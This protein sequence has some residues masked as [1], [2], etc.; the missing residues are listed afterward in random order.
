[1]VRRSSIVLALL[2]VLLVAAVPA[3]GAR[4]QARPHDGGTITTRLTFVPDCLDPDKTTI[5]TAIFSDVLDTLISKDDQGRLSPDLATRWT[6]GN[7]GKVI[8]FFLRHGVKFSN[9]DAFTAQDVKFTLARGLKSP[10]AS[11]QFG[12]LKRVKVTNPYTVRL[13]MSTPYRPLFTN[14][15]G[16]YGGIMDPAAVRRLGNKTCTDPVGTGPFMIKS[17]G[18]GFN[19]VV[20]VRNPLHTWNPP[21]IKN[22]FGVAHIARLVF[23][24]IVSDSTATSELLTGGVDISQVVADQLPRV[25]SNANIRLRPLALPHEEYLGFNTARA[26]FNSVA[27]RRALAE[28]V[29]RKAIMKVAVGSFGTPAYSALPDL[30]PFYDKRSPSYAVQYNPTAARSVL[31]ANHV[32][33]PYTL[34]TYDIP[35]SRTAAE[36]MQA[37]LAQVGVTTNVVIKSFA[38]GGSLLSKGN[39]DLYLGQYGYFDA[40]ILYLFFH[41]SQEGKGNN[42]TF[43]KNPT[44]DALLTAGNSTYN[45]QTAGAIYAKV[46]KLLD[47]EVV[48]DP[49][50]NDRYYWGVRTKVKGFWHPGEYEIPYQDLWV[51]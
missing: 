37:E 24:P 48:T 15:A 49:L 41:S 29:D 33:G 6:I 26:P 7:G 27:V 47:T 16:G 2:S 46:Q 8:T 13:I 1:M 42:F 39:Y 11:S 20:L 31:Q 43:Y 36:L 21:W 38:D 40:F 51:Q 25:K 34:L 4:P 44:L 23:K 3:R 18:P 45:T 28:A 14:L 9:G 32:T 5:D 17:V 35:A 50:W 19:P 22:Q 10:T 30:L 12:P